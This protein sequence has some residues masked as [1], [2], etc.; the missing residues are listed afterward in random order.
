[1][2]IFLFTA[3]VIF[4]NI[5]FFLQCLDAFAKWSYENRSFKVKDII[6]VPIKKLKSFQLPGEKSDSLFGLHDTSPEYDRLYF[7]SPFHKTHVGVG[8]RLDATIPRG[9]HFKTFQKIGNYNNGEPILPIFGVENKKIILELRD[10][11]NKTLDRIKLE[12]LSIKLPTDIITAKIVTIEDIDEYGNEEIV[13]IINAD[14]AGLPRGIAVHDLI[15]GKKKWEYLF[16]PIPLEV[17]VRDINHDGKKEIIFSAWAPHNNFSYNNMNDDTSYVGA[18]D[19][20]GNLL[21]QYKAGGYYSKEYLAVEDLDINGTF[22]VIIARS[23][24]RD[25]PD[26][27]QIRVCDALTGEIIETANYPGISFTNIFVINMDNDPNLEII[28]CDTG[29]GLRI[30]HHDLKVYKEFKGDT[31]IRILGVEKVQENPFP[32]IFTWY[33]YNTLRI[34]DHKLRTIFTYKFQK[35]FLSPDPIIPVS[36]GKNTSYVLATDHTYRISSKPVIAFQDLI[37]LLRS[38]FSLYLLGIFVFNGFL[39]VGWRQRKKIRERYLE[40]MGK[41]TKTNPQWTVTAQESLHKM[42]SPLT[43]ILW[44]TEKIDGLL[45]K[46]RPSKTSWPKLREINDAILDD[47][48]ELKLMNHFLMK[49]LKVQTLHL[50]EI[51]IKDI[52]TCLADK[53]QRSF[54]N[55]FTFACKFPSPLPS[56]LADEEQLKEMFSNIIDNAIDAM[57]DGGIISISA[58]YYKIL[59]GNKKK[60]IVC[61]EIEDNGCGISKDKLDTIFEPYYTTKKE[62]TG[63]GLAIA[64]RIVESHEGWIKVESREKIGTKFAL[65][66]P[67]KTLTH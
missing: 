24:H 60:N 5:L 6:H 25:I 52:I 45:E 39:Y 46:K 54:G 4:V 20:S 14:R 21:W 62:G 19:C 58:V 27:G 13:S 49:Y 44:E 34:F 65:Y 66:F 11:D 30:W 64:R 23:C 40:L 63:I 33:S 16:G 55:K 31:D 36:D 17:I 3:A 18:L 50:Q 51:N 41:G 10:I 7:F 48:N 53:Y 57:A 29:G 32:S 12:N 38:H 35:E 56:L 61:V 42:K 43:A 37:L 15:S 2:K 28:S 22:E 1:M 67:L 8:V 47:L 9:W 26:P 59:P